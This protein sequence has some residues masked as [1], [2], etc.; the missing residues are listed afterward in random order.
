LVA[1]G[2]LIEIIFTSEADLLGRV[3]GSSGSAHCYGL[4]SVSVWCVS[5]SLTHGFLVSR[6]VSVGVL[7]AVLSG[8]RPRWTCIPHWYITFSM[9]SSIVVPS[10]GEE[11]AKIATLLLVP[12][13]LGD[14]RVWQWGN[15]SIPVR[16]N[17]RGAALAAHLVIRLQTCIIYAAAVTSKLTDVAWLRGTA[18]YFVAYEPQYGFPSSIRALLSPLVNSYWFVAPLTWLVIGTEIAIAITILGTLKMRLVAVALGACLHVAIGL[19]LGLPS[20][21]L[22]MIGLL[23]IAAGGRFSEVRSKDPVAAGRN[24]D[25]VGRLVEEN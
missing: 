5:S 16:P 6:I 7:A 2:T 4:G 25:I 22:V 21:A 11:V 19:L 13:C 20:F 18:M 17:W 8:Y 23:I 14:T 1:V 10:G 24:S 9:A 15:P 12:I 3:S